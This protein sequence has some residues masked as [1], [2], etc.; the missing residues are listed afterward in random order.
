MSKGLGKLFGRLGSAVF[1][2]S[3]LAAL[4]TFMSGFSGD[5]ALLFGL[6]FIFVSVFVA[7]FVHE[8]GHALTAIAVGWEIVVF[9]VPPFAV[10]VRN[11]DF[12]FIWKTRGIEYPRYGFVALVPASLAVLTW[13]RRLA[14]VSGGPAASFLFGTALLAVAGSAFESDSR[15]WALIAGFAITSLGM[16]FATLLPD[17]A[18]RHSSDGTQIWNLLRHGLKADAT[19]AFGYVSAMLEFRVR[20]RDIPQWLLDLMR[21]GDGGWPDLE[22]AKASLAVSCSLDAVEVDPVSVRALI[23]DFRSKYGTSEWLAACDAYLA[24]MYENDPERAAAAL[25]D[26]D[27]QGGTPELTLAAEAAVAASKGQVAFA[28][29]K[30]DE[31]DKLLALK[32]PFENK[33][34]SDIRAAIEVV[35][36]RESARILP[37]G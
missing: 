9:S 26:G 5:G 11:G 29:S 6:L 36:I 18:S 7:T 25:S 33:T 31:M 23:E 34:F 35:A 37:V 30:L 2:I 22:R 28:R 14:L 8:A 3:Y 10:Q 21:H 17:Q 32:S 24:V 15:A 4:F 12:R 16:S 19:L 1:I 13:K 27:G 20:L